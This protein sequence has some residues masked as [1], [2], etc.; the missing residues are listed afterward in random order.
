MVRNI[1]DVISEVQD[2]GLSRPSTGYI[3]VNNNTSAAAY[4]SSSQPAAT[5]FSLNSID[6]DI[7][8]TTAQP[9]YSA[10]S[11]ATIQSNPVSSMV[12]ATSAT[13]TST[14]TVSEN[15]TSDTTDVIVGEGNTV[16]QTPGNTTIYINNNDKDTVYVTE[17]TKEYVQQF[18]TNSGTS[19]PGGNNE[20]IQFN[21]NGTFAASDQLT[22][23]IQTGTLISTDA[24]IGNITVGSTAFLGNVA[25]VHIDGGINSYV[26]TTDGQGNLRWAAPATGNG[27]VGGAFT[28]LQFNDNGNFGGISSATYDGANLSLGQAQFLKILGGSSGQV[29]TTDGTGNLAWEDSGGGLLTIT[30]ILTGGIYNVTPDEEVLVIR[31]AAPITIV[32]A[33]PVQVG[34]R[35][36]IKDF[37][38]NNRVGNN[39]SI[40]GTGGDTVDGAGGFSIDEPYNVISVIGVSSTEW[41]IL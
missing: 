20:E 10:Y 18:I 29:L 22:F 9:A 1:G 5:A 11:A 21:N 7:G 14:T 27:T 31:A 8:I 37:V 41:M 17:I 12:G 2:Q 28:T 16:I 32:L 30:S 19:T 40:L 25:N 4:Q 35:I 26:L 34:R 3:T 39:I 15:T 38:G 24:R 13:G 33:T 23:D 6:T 36:I